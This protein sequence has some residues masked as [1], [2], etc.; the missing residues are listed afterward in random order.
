LFITILFGGDWAD[1]EQ[2]KLSATAQ[3]ILDARSLFPNSTLADLYD[4]LTMPIELLKAHQ[5]NN[6]AVDEIYGFKGEA[7][8]ASRVTFLFKKYEELTS[9]LPGTTVKKKRIRKD[10]AQSD[11]I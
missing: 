1:A 10:D 9:I 2:E 8:D 4:P 6:K 11:L 7:D 3:A 5:A